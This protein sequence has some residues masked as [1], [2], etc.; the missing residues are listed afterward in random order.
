MAYGSELVLAFTADQFKMVE[1]VLN[2]VINLDDQEIVYENVNN[3]I[4]K[5]LKT[6]HHDA[7]VVAG[8]TVHEDDEL[9]ESDSQVAVDTDV[10]R[11]EMYPFVL[12]VFYDPHEIG[13]LPKHAKVGVA[14]SGRYQPTFLDYQDENG[15]LMD[16][17][18]D[19]NLVMI[20]RDAIAAHLPIFKDAKLMIVEKHY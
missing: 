2:A 12:E 18:I 16:V 17:P 9:Y 13:D 8:W 3:D 1:A 14:I 6:A 15:T 19:L 7:C 4:D 11:R 5:I 10:G 20:A